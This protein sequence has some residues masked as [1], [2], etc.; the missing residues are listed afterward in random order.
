MRTVP[1][2]VAALLGGLALGLAMSGHA[3]ENPRVPEFLGTLRGR[4]YTHAYKMPRD[5]VCHEQVSAGVMR[6]ELALFKTVDVFWF[7]DAEG[8][9]RNAV[10]EDVTTN[11]YDVRIA[12]SRHIDYSFR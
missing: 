3:Q 1:I 8:I 12:P 11:L 9:V 4:T 7:R 10:L 6:G 2:V 5:I